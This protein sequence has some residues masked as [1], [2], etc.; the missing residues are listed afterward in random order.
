MYPVAIILSGITYYHYSLILTGENCRNYVVLEPLVA[1]SQSS[2]PPTQLPEA[3]S[4]WPLQTGP[5]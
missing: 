5:T 4:L 2:K 3:V 1:K